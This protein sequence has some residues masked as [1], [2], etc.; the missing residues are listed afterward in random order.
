VEIY[1]DT[2]IAGKK[3]EAGALVNAQPHNV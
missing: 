3:Q 1:D 2:V